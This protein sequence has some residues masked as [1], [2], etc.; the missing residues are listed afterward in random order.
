MDPE[1]VNIIPNWL[2]PTNYKQLNRFLGFVGFYRRFV[3][4]YAIITQLLNH[5]TRGYQVG[6]PSCKKG[7]QRQ[8]TSGGRVPSPTEHF[9]IQWDSHHE[10]IQHL[11]KMPVLPYMTA[12]KLEFLILKLA[13]MKKFKDNLYVA[14]FQD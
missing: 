3:E 9:R 4:I 14:T 6:S 10:I 5:L 11:I 12:R 13:V 8:F 2:C 1:K 7:A